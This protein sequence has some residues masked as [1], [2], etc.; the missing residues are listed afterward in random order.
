MSDL[1]DRARE[2]MAI[3]D[4]A[5]RLV[6]KMVGS[7]DER[8]S[9]CPLCR[10]GELTGSNPFKVSLRRQS[11]NCFMCGEHGDVVD[12]YSKAYALTG[13]EAAKEIA[14]AQHASGIERKLK[15]RPEL[16]ADDKDR[17]A[18]AL[19]RAVDMWRTAVDFAGS[20]GEAYLLARG[21]SPAI[22]GMVDGPRF[23]PAAPHHW[24]DQAR[25]W[26]TAPAIVCKVETAGG[27]GGGVHV[28][29]LTAGGRAKAALDPA[30]RMWGP[31]GDQ[32]P[33]GVRPGGAWLIGKDAAAG[34]LVTGEGIETVLSLASWLHG[35]GK[36]DLRACAS[37][38]L[39]RLQGGVR[40]DEDGCVDIWRP[41]GDPARPP[42]LWPPCDTGPLGPSAAAFLAIDR[43]MGPVRVKGRNGRGRQ[44]WFELDAEARAKLCARLAERAWRGAGWRTVRPMWPR[45]GGDW[46]DIVATSE[47]RPE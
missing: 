23:H 12:L 34:D 11:F 19:K 7:R 35:H 42:F 43:D 47:G 5:D 4:L 30:K 44:T 18:K 32:T 26:I 9:Y 22:V 2:A 27:W 1:F 8:R 46:N 33:F 45:V 6:V 14:G 13:Y 28:T 39:N 36:S 15:P 37:L 16:A 38:S 10:A 17:E 21:V 31:Q 40:R 3:E 29:Y 20:I 25:A 24:D 41:M